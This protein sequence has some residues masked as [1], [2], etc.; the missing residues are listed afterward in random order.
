[1]TYEGNDCLFWPFARSDNG[2][3]RLNGRFTHRMV[4]E[5]THGPPPTPEHQAAHS[6]GKGN[7]A[8]VTKGHLSWKTPMQNAADKIA[9]GTHNRGERHNLAK[10]TESEVLA[11]RKRRHDGEPLDKLANDYNVSASLVGLIHLRKVWKWLDA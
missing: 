10:L 11:I 7:L 6:C 8:C 3:G 4:C 1:M 5:E 9:H 2:Y